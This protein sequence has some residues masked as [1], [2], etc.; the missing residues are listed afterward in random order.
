M[1]YKCTNKHCRLYDVEKNGEIKVCPNCGIETLV[2]QYLKYIP[3][4]F[5][6][7]FTITLII[8]ILATAG[9]IYLQYFSENP[10]F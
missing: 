4:Y 9:F 7:L 2:Y 8:A 1:K 5:Q 6:V 3:T 10:I